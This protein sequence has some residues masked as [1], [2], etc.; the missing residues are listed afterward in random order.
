MEKFALLKTLGQGLSL[1]ATR[2]G[3]ALIRSQTLP[4]GAPGRSQKRSNLKRLGGFFCLSGNVLQCEYWP[5]F[6]EK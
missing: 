4:G 2:P 5:L 6:A 1:R 3:E